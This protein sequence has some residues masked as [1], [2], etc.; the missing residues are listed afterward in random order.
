[1]YKA[2]LACTTREKTKKQKRQPR[3]RHVNFVASTAKYARKE[4]LDRAVMRPD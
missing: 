2:L 4:A 3:L 1:M